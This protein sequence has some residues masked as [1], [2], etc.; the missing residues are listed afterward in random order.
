MIT[1]VIARIAGSM[2]PRKMITCH[3]MPMPVPSW[4]WRISRAMPAWPRL[5]SGAI[6]AAPL[7]SSTATVA[8]LPLA[9]L[10]VNCH[11]A[12]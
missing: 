1:P 2:P 9:G 4:I 6:D 11:S 10:I 7:A 5:A 3:T 12:L 8:G